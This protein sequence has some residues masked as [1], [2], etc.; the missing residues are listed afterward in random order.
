[1]RIGIEV[2]VAKKDSTVPGGRGFECSCS[3]SALSAAAQGVDLLLLGHAPRC[4]S[5]RNW[6][7]ICNEFESYWRWCNGVA[8]L[9]FSS[10]IYALFSNGGATD[11][12]YHYRV[13]RSLLVFVSRALFESRSIIAPVFSE[14]ES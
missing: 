11:Y 4:G 8:V 5:R 14:H 3:R 13:L 2:C 6:V 9:S 10:I 7:I 12:N 1:M